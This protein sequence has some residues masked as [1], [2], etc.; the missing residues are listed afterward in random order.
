[1][2]LYFFLQ[3]LISLPKSVYFNFR[4]LPWQQAVHLPILVHWHTRFDSLRRNSIVIEGGI[5]PFMIK[6]GIGGTRKVIARRTVISSVGKLVFHGSGYLGRGILLSNRGTMHVG[7]GFNSNPNVSIWCVDAVTI[8][9]DTLMGADITIRDN[10][11][12]EVFANGEKQEMS[13]P[14]VIGDHVWLCDKV[15]VLKGGAVAEGSI[16]AFQS[17]ITKA[18]REPHVLIAGIPGRIVKQNVDWKN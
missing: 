7:K 13:R 12:H 5:K 17:V 2:N 1:M 10:D 18:F 3:Y 16:A 11:G 9:D 15:V 14:V 6:L 4:C 8:G